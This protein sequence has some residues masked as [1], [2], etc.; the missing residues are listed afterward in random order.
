MSTK[1]LDT[2]TENLFRM[3]EIFNEVDR[4]KKLVKINK[5]LLGQISE[6][7]KKIECAW[8]EIEL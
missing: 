8:K 4:I 1:E 2:K 6:S 7:V 5:E 3:E